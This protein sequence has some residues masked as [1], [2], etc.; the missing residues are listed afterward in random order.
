MLLHQNK[1]DSQARINKRV[2][3]FFLKNYTSTPNTEEEFLE[4]KQQPQNYNDEYKSLF[5]LLQE[6][7]TGLGQLGQQMNQYEEVGPTAPVEAQISNLLSQIN[8]TMNQIATTCQTYTQTPIV[9]QGL[10]SQQY[11]KLLSM[12]KRILARIVVGSYIQKFLTHYAPAP[13]GGRPPFFDE[14]Q[15]VMSA[16]GNAI[17]ALSTMLDTYLGETPTNSVDLTPVGAGRKGARSKT[18]KGDLDYTTKKGDKVYHRAG[19]YIY[20]DANPPFA[21]YYPRQRFM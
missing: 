8:G 14:L 13:V 15:S 1:L 19:H 21:E 18:H 6:G 7:E 20:N 11:D 9:V 10:S 4:T 5:Q 2:L 12:L 3:G 17:T 16:C